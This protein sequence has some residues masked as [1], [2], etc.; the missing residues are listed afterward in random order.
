MPRS[1]LFVSKYHFARLALHTRRRCFTTFM[2]V[3]A[4]CKNLT[5]RPLSVRRLSTA[6]DSDNNR[7]TTFT[8]AAGTLFVAAVIVP[9]FAVLF[10][11]RK[12]QQKLLK[13]YGDKN[14]YQ[15]PFVDTKTG[16]LFQFKGSWFPVVMFPDLQRFEQIR[17][18]TLNDDDIL[19]D[20]F[21][22]SGSI[23]TLVI[24]AVILLFT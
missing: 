16:S 22:K 15:T 24:A 11:Y 13:K 6:G 17:D 19:V 21:P 10:W 20:S 12:E 4:F 3:H 1:S 2:T 5:G 7:S 9:A 8:S 14:I 23:C 18:F